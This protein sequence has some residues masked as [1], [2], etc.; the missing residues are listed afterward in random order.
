MELKISKKQIFNTCLNTLSTRAE[1]SRL[2]M[3]ESQRAANE[4]GAPRDRYDS[5]R[6][7]VLA[8]RDMYARQYN[9]ALR[10]LE[11]LSKIDPGKPCEMVEFGALVVTSVQVLFVSVGLGKLSDNGVDF[12]AISAGVPLFEAIRGKRNGDT[13]TFRGTTFTI[14]SVG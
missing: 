4:Y 12:Y 6:T 5:F 13:F 10:Q 9:E 11:V 7:Q 2:A 14:V 8:R 3:V 1:E